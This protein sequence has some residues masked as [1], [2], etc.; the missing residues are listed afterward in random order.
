VAADF[1]LNLGKIGQPIRV[2]VTSGPVSPPIDV[3]LWL[4]GQERTVQR[5]G[6]AIELIEVRAA[7]SA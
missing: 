1:D 7:A 3:T 6:S 2:A 4:V 5:L